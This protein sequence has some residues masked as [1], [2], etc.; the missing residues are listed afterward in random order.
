MGIRKIHRLMGLIFAPFFL[1]T[2]LT[3]IILLW[4][5]AGIYEKGTKN[6]LLGMHNWEIASSYIGVI[7]ACS[8]LFMTI[9]GLIMFFKTR[10]R[11]K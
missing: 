9:S 11:R 1:I 5:K 8:L 4:R 10:R 3:G 2:S 6:F 7:L